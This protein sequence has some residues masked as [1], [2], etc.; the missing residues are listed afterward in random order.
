MAVGVCGRLVAFDLLVLENGLGGCRAR[1]PGLTSP[2]P[3][4]LSNVSA[5][6]A[7]A[8]TY[9]RNAALVSL[10]QPVLALPTE[11]IETSAASLPT[12]A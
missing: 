4:A 2:P 10:S 5:L 3:V 1:L 7:P 8:A 11:R 9:R 6:A 12:A